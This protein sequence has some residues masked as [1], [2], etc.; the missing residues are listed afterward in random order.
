MKTDDEGIRAVRE[1][2][3]KISAECANDPEKLVE[4]YVAEQE[5]YRERL[6]RPVPA[7]QGDKMGGASRSR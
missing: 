3:E 5:R 7:Q 2:R 6:L 1:V 4:H